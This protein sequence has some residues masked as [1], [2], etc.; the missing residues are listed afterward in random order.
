DLPVDNSTVLTA[1]NTNQPSFGNPKTPNHAHDWFSAA[2]IAGLAGNGDGFARAD[3]HGDPPET[4][5]NDAADGPS[6][7]RDGKVTLLEWFDYANGLVQGLTDGQDPEIDDRKEAAANK[8]AMKVIFV[9]ANP[10]DPNNNLK[11]HEVPARGG[12]DMGGC[13]PRAV[14]GIAEPVTRSGGAPVS[15]SGGGSG[16]SAGAAG[17]IVGGAAAAALA[18]GWFARRRWVR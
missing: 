8:M 5:E 16:P 12:A 13:F 10:G 15:S 17:A 7:Q 14:G 11:E 2:L 3:V 6:K 9:Y 4:G 18:G 1:S